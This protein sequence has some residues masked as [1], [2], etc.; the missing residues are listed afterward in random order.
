MG[1]VA[2][3]RAGKEMGSAERVPDALAGL[4]TVDQGRATGDWQKTPDNAVA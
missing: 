3:A 2:A 1:P 4:K